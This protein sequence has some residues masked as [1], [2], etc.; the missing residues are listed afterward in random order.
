[1]GGFKFFDDDGPRTLEP[2]DLQTLARRGDIDFPDITER[3]IR[4][5]SKGDV[6]SKGIVVIQTSWFIL[7]CIARRIERLPITK[8][9]LVTLAVAALNF[10][11]YALWWN[12][13]LDVQCP[14]CVLKKQQKSKGWE[15]VRRPYVKADKK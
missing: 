7:Q 4:D 8:L 1:M 15:A 9:E 10:V 11:T 14:V 2:Q 6:L 5:K 13:P 3:E 12:K